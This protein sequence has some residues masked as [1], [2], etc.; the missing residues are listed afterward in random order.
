MYV[1]E[2]S[3]LTISRSTLCISFELPLILDDAV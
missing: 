2:M 1:D 3:V